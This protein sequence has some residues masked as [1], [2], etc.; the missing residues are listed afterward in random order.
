MN[1][2][3]V[4]T[5][6]PPHIRQRKD[7]VNF[8]PDLIAEEAVGIPIDAHGRK[9][10]APDGAVLTAY[11]RD[12]SHVSIIRGPIGS[13]SSSGSIMK[14]YAISLEQRPNPIDGIRRTRWGVV[15]NTFP[16][17]RGTT[18]KTWLDW[19]P[20][21]LYGRFYWDRPYRHVIRLGDVEMEVFFLALDSPDDVQKLRSLEV[22][23]WWFNEMEFQNKEIVDEAESRTGRFP[24][25]KDG[26]CTWDG[27]LGDMNAPNEDHW[28]P[29]VMGE[30][31]FPDSWTEEERLA[32][33]KP[34]GWSYFVQ[35]PALLEVRDG[36]GR[37]SG[38]KINPMAE[39]L[40]WLKPGFYLEKM[41]GKSRQWILSRLMNVITI[42]VEGQAVWPN[43]NAETHISREEIKP[44]EGWPIYVGLD[45]GRNPAAVVGQLVSNRWRIFA[46]L[47]AKQSGA[48]TFAPLVKKLLDA[49]LG[50][51]NCPGGFDVHF[52]GDPKGQDGVQTDETTAYEVWGSFGMPVRPAPNLK[53][54]QIATRIEAVE[55]ALN[56]MVNG[57]PR[58]QL[59]PVNCRVGKV[60]MSGGYHFARIKG[61]AQHAPVPFKDKYSDWADACQYMVLGGGEG[62]AMRTAGGGLRPVA[63]QAFKKSGNGRRGGF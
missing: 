60:A 12:R 22:T 36:V 9:I 24:A 8:R 7:L 50:Y 3:A 25:V 47:H 48:T 44:V 42:Y 2:P 46:E 5:I 51:W 19:F 53:N 57:V 26:G 4:E 1:A 35:P 58:F 32:Y 16:E 11:L 56:G 23:G 30:V 34:A 62:R 63:V 31:D 10:Y 18:I 17:L 37:I 49:R 40:R 27:V 38:Y 13:G 41:R 21:N 45:F 29:L 61:T 20:E 55:Y 28:V 33:Q 52:F 54:N 6:I 59:C 15:R 43:F 14:M 39:N